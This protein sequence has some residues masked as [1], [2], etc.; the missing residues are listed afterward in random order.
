MNNFLSFLQYNNTIPIVLSLVLVGAGSTFAYQNPE[1][2]YQ[3]EVVVKAIDNTY[4]ANLNLDTYSPTIEVTKVEESE[5]HYYIT[6]LLSTIS[7]KDHIWQETDLE[8][9]LTIDKNILVRYLNLEAYVTKELSEVIAKE[10][11]DLRQTQVFERKAL[12]Q[13]TIVTTHRGLVGKFVDDKTEVLPPYQ[14]IME[15]VN[16][17]TPPTPAPAPVFTVVPE[18]KIKNSE[19]NETKEDKTE[20]INI[21]EEEEIEELKNDTETKIEEVESEGEIEEIEETETEEKI[22]TE[23]QSQNGEEETTEEENENLEG[24]EIL[25]LEENKEEINGDVLEEEVEEESEGEI[26]EKEGEEREEI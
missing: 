4:L 16:I 3:E 1:T 6:Y 17:P 8:K 10:L 22:E 7:L 2:F 21:T 19:K 5:T 20:Q 25:I 23:T 13:K 24:E 9:N 14:P 11:Q 15:P 18:E 26:G 12:S